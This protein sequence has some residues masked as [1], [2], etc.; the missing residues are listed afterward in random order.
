[1]SDAALDSIKAFNTGYSRDFATATK[2]L[3][4]I[5][6]GADVEIT[7]DPELG[8]EMSGEGLPCYIPLD[9]GEHLVNMILQCL[10]HHYRQ[11][12]AV[13]G[14]PDLHDVT[15]LQRK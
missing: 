5:R 3:F 8:W 4:A 11:L 1:M 9:R 13:L 2:V 7:H 10:V 12:T 15:M 6:V 14:N